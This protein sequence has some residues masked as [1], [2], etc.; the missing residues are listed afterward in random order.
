MC[1]ELKDLP[2]DYKCSATQLT[3]D[4]VEQV[5]QHKSWSSQSSTAWIGVDAT[6]LENFLVQIMLTLE[7]LIEYRC[8]TKLKHADTYPAHSPKEHVD[9]IEVEITQ[10]DKG[11]LYFAH[12]VFVPHIFRERLRKGLCERCMLYSSLM[13][14]QRGIR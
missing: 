13:I 4:V 2:V 10:P 6:G 8:P 1:P 5:F 11:T 12:H 3:E 7:V 9:Q 14:Y